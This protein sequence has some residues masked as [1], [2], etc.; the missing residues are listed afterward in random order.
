MSRYEFRGTDHRYRL[1]VGWDQ[2]LKSYFCQVED[3]AWGS[4]GATID[5][6]AMI[7]DGPEEGLLLWVSGDPPV[8]QRE[9]LA[10]ALAPYGK[11]PGDLW[12]RLYLDYLNS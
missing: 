8:Y 1:V 4:G 10:E 12:D 6:D 7:G 5:E 9:K 3:L 2:G 11:I